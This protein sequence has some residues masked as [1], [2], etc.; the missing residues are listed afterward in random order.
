MRVSILQKIGLVVLGIFLFFVILEVVLNIGGF[1]F[2]ALQEY[3]NDISFKQKGVYR[4]LCLGESTTA[5]GGEDSYPNQLESILNQRK[6]GIRFSVINNGV[7]GIISSLILA[8]LNDDLDKYKPDMVI[9]MMGINDSGVHMLRETIFKSKS[10]QFL[11]LFKTYKLARMIRLHFVTKINEKKIYQ[12]KVDDREIEQDNFSNSEYKLKKAIEINPDDDRAYLELG[13]LNYIYYRDKVVAKDIPAIYEAIGLQDA[14]AYIDLGYVYMEKNDISAA[15]RSFL[16]ALELNPRDDIAYTG[17]GCVYLNK[18]D[19]PAAKASFIR[20]SELNPKN[21]FA[22]IELAWLCEEQG[23]LADAEE[24]LNKAI[25]AN[26]YDDEAYVSLG[27]LVIFRGDFGYAR[28]LF[29]KARYLNSDNTGAVKG[30]GLINNDLGPNKSINKKPKM[31]RRDKWEYIESYKLWRLIKANKISLAEESIKKAITLNGRNSYAYF[32]LGM[33]YKDRGNILEAEEAFK[34]VIELYPKEP[35]AYMELG[36][37]FVRKE[38][39]IKAE[40]FFRKAAETDPN[41]DKAYGALVTIAKEVND[42][43]TI[44]KYHKKADDLRF[45]YYNPVTITNYRK[46]AAV[47]EKRKI[48]LV[49]VQY[50]VRGIKSL[51]SIFI[52]QNDVIFVDNEEIFKKALLKGSYNEYFTDM[53]GGDFGHCTTKGNKLLAENIANII[54]KKVFNK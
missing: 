53:F 23:R 42:F 44:E 24:L 45:K 26:P 2:S 9:A 12:R 50:P 19:I 18:N 40:E 20:A 41:N 1:L 52:G 4:I 31:S 27:M 39:F 36:W 35:Q 13:R 30:L 47:L 21:Y 43:D 28:K 48:K 7:P 49:C 46:L 5:V 37:L 51:K 33:I 15:E 8:R 34:K 54:L 14:L 11:S 16:K 3:R 29:K 25:E 6:A 10:M 17:L 22:Y 32:E 38:D